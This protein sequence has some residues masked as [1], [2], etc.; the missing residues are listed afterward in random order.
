[1]RTLTF[2]RVMESSLVFPLKLD[3]DCNPNA[4]LVGAFCSL[5][6]MLLFAIQSCLV[7]E[8]KMLTVVRDGL[9]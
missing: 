6:I 5:N 8:V 2:H 4:P 7:A 9:I 1:M 3:S